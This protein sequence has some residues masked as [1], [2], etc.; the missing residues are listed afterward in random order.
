M[1]ESAGGTEAMLRV[2]LA[3][4]PEGDGFWLC[5]E[6]V[7]AMFDMNLG[8]WEHPDQVIVRMAVTAFSESAGGTEAML[9]V[10]LAAFTERHGFGCAQERR[11]QCAIRIIVLTKHDML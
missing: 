6:A 5:S 4:S 8:R 2:G 3:V 10:G 7:S 9:D 1:S 11:A